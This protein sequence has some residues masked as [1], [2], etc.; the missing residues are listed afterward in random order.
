MLPGGRVLDSHPGR[1]PS[2]LLARRI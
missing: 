2:R 1:S